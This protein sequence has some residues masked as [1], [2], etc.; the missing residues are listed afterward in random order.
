[1][2]RFLA[3]FLC[4]ALLLS[5]PFAGAAEILF[6]DANDD[7][8]VNVR[9][10]GLMQQHLN[11]WNV[12]FSAA[13]ADVNADGK[14][15][16]RDLGLMQQYLNGW[17]V[18]LGQPNNPV[19][20]DIYVVPSS[21]FDPNQ[22]VTITFAHTMGILL[23]SV[24]NESIAE[25][26]KIYPN[27]HIEHSSYGGW[28][29]IKEW[30][31][32]E[33]AAGTQPNLAYCYPDHMVDYNES[34]ATVALDN[35][36]NHETLG[37]TA[38]QKDDY[39]DSFWKAGSVYEDGHTYQLAM[40]QSTEVMFYNK[41]FFDQHGLSVPTTW[42]EM[43]EVCAQIKA[44][45]PDSFPLT[46]DSEDNWFATMCEQMQSGYTSAENGGEYLFNN[47]TNKAW[48]KELREYYDKEYFITQDLYGGYTSSLFTEEYGPRCYMS[49]SSSGG[50][51]YYLPNYS[52]FEV[53]IASVPQYDPNRRRTV[54]QGPSLCILKGANTTDQEI[55]ASWLFMKYLC[56][57]VKFQTEFSRRA[58]YMPVIH[59]AITDP[60]YDAWLN[61]ADGYHNITARAVAVCIDCCDNYFVRPVFKGSQ[62]AYN[63]LGDLLVTCIFN[64]A[65]GGD[66]DALINS[67][68]DQA[69]QACEAG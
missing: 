39:I 55:L 48:I 1:M 61:T 13:A 37:F 64:P 31:G 44:I 50:A 8:K 41:T 54:T 20:N 45:D 7:G 24:L 9:D 36:I 60:T 21:G 52:E 46:Y 35:L 67:L 18:I 28:S 47:D 40:S 30:L 51:L 15:N 2:K 25:F 12:T 23:Q 56:T 43:W 16:V 6:G 3:L 26:N 14:V 32:F 17:N 65:P 66:V 68:F 11:G 27:I 62:N 42:E 22:E 5:V 4:A 19:N 34:K 69:Q 53:G 29:D 10:V 58:G 38:A 49:I 63:V 33:I 57:N 59:S